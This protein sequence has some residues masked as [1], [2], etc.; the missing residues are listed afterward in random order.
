MI[1]EALLLLLIQ[2]GRAR[3]KV[4]P[5]QGCVTFR[6]KRKVDRLDVD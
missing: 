3:I 6:T 4:K 1:E 5:I 2:S